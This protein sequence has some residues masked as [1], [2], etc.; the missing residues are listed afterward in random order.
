MSSG[1]LE[2]VAAVHAPTIATSRPAS[3]QRNTRAGSSVQVGERSRLR[4]RAWC[5]RKRR[6]STAPASN[7][8]IPAVSPA[9]EH[10]TAPNTD[11]AHR[12]TDQQY[13]GRCPVTV[14]EGQVPHT[15]ITT[16]VD[17]RL[18]MAKK[19]PVA[20]TQRLRSGSVN[21]ASGAIRRL[22]DIC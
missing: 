6:S 7:G 5:R 19:G 15:T 11:K 10:P 22:V 1:G 13:G 17:A 3:H 18:S 9:R 2:G 16:T 21:P 12:P 8:E 4:A 20:I 14:R